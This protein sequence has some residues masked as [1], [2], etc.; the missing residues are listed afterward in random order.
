MVKSGSKKCGDCC[1]RIHK[2]VRFDNSR[3]MCKGC[4]NFYHFKCTGISGNTENWLCNKCLLRNLPFSNLD[5]SDFLLTLEGKLFDE[6]LRLNLFPS[7]STQ[8]LLDTIPGQ[9]YFETDEF[10]SDSISSKYYTPTEFLK[11]KISKNSFS[12]F[13]MNIASLQLHINELRSLISLL[14]HPFS[15]IGISETK[16][17]NEPLKNI[18]IPGYVFHGIESTTN[19]GG[20]GFYIRNDLDFSIRK[21]LNKTSNNVA[22]SF[23]CE[24]SLKNRKILVGVLYRHHTSINN[25]VD[26][27]F[28]DILQKITKE[29]NKSC[30]IMGDF[31]C[32][33]LKIDD[34]DDINYFY[35]MLT[36][37]SFRP[38]VLQPTR[39]TSKSS[40]LIDNIFTNDMSLS[41]VGGN[42]TS[43]ISDHFSQFCTLDVYEK[44][45]KIKKN[46][47]GRSFKNFN[48][49]EFKNELLKIDWNT[50][51]NGLSVNEQV[52]KFLDKIN[53]LLDELAPVRT[54]TKKENEL[55]QNPWLTNGILKSMSLRDKKYKKF[56]CAKNPAL[57]QQIFDNFKTRRNLINSLV[58]NAKIKYYQDFFSEYSKNAKKTWEGIRD[59]L[60]VSTKNKINPKKLTHQ[61]VEIKDLR[62]MA[63][64]FNDFFV[65]IGNTVENKIPK[66]RKNYRD[67]L[68]NSIQNTIFLS[69]VSDE[70]I[71]DMLRNINSKKSCGP[72]NIPSNLLKI[73]AENFVLPLK[74]MINQSFAEGIFPNC[75][76]SAQICPIYKKGSADIRENYRPISLLSNLSKIFERAMHHRVYNFLESNDSF[77][78]QQFG[79][80]KKHS[81]S[82]A[83]LN[84]VEEIRKNLDNKTYSCGVFV[85]L[86]K[87]FDT[88]N[89]KILLKKLDHY[90]IRDI[91]NNWFESYLSNRKQ[92]VQLEN[93]KSGYLN[94]TC[95][96][97][98]GSIL[99][100]LLF[101]IYINDM[102]D[103][104][105]FCKVY[106]FAD[107]TN[108][109]YSHKNLKTLRKNINKDLDTL[110]DWLCANRLSLNV[111]KTEFIIF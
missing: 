37:H 108:L 2:S 25:F 84:I 48:N 4:F 31:N 24:I 91:S 62:K 38:L 20:C 106:H 28:S 56:L 13:H 61:G 16:I 75:L 22:E 36:S 46:I 53:F 90:G 34:H 50:M 98:Q 17:R 69:P 58:R 71:F 66:G 80:R 32:D 104:F 64:T 111:S 94:I 107:D 79:F 43:S 95:G 82:H 27:F 87:A 78:D 5:Q 101:I 85:D 109:L 81:T 12:V 9:C 18:Q 88:V 29:K 89:H 74:I 3:Y 57:K 73:N 6:N 7:F 23:F 10:L 21:K 59:I 30:I 67:F 102:H 41:S 77:F 100:P 49:E 35:N 92:Y 93:E 44:N 15:V 52:E 103:A 45:K 8:T 11:A 33:L 70:E 99:G 97:P 55:R 1:R 47:K 54:L 68:K 26:N 83:I 76:K 110:F 72:N 19:C 60:K 51:L 96:V 40:T 65:N 86:E 63:S 14:D 42:I 39:V 105:E